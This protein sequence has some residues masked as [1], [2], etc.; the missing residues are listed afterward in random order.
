MA[1]TQTR[2]YELDLYVQ[3]NPGDP[4]YVD[5]DELMY[6]VD[7]ETF[8]RPKRQPASNFGESGDTIN[9]Q[10]DI[11][12][13]LTDRNI[14]VVFSTAF[15]SMPVTV[16]LKAYRYKQ[17]GSEYIE[18]P[19]LFKYPSTGWKTMTGFSIIID[20]DESLTGVYVEYYFE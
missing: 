13:G 7:H 15:T 9:R 2:P 5:P 17:I 4:G 10:K 18:V 16:Q 1:L 14:T 8:D 12:S 3:L 6:M 19:V 11:L 20:P